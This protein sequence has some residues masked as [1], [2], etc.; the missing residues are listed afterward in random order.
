[1]T[2]RHDRPAPGAHLH[3]KA[4]ER[5]L[6][7]P[8]EASPIPPPPPPKRSRIRPKRPRIRPKRPS[9]PAALTLVARR[10]IEAL[11]DGLH[12]SETLT[13]ARFEEPN[14]DVFKNALVPGKQV[15]EDFGVKKNQI[16]EIVLVAAPP[17]SRRCGS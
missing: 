14:A 1:M 5:S 17:G 13:R 3:Q 7:G 11:Y 8:P 2:V 6:G 16:D 9:G 15:M 4:W 10:G 12:F